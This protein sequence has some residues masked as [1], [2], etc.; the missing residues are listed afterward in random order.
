MFWVR[1]IAENVWVVLG[2][3]AI[4]FLWAKNSFWIADGIPLNEVYLHQTTSNPPRT[5]FGP[6]VN[7][8]SSTSIISPQFETQHGFH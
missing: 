7:Q 3:S 8:Y 4:I 1:Q 5:E 2:G 6:V